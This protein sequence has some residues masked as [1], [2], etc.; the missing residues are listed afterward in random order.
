MP[1]CVRPGWKRRGLWISIGIAASTACLAVIAAVAICSHANSI[2][3]KFVNDTGQSVVLPD[4]GPD[5][6]Q[7]GAGQAAVINVDKQ[8]Q[9]CSIDGTRGSG[10]TVVGCLILPSPHEGKAVVRLSDARPVSRSHPCG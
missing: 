10:E 4:C 7:L 6:E 1:R 9:H 5:L 8:T 3:V 2:P